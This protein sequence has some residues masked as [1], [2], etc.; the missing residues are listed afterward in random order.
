MA[1]FKMTDDPATLN[2]AAKEALSKALP[3]V[4]DIPPPA[5]NLVTLPGGLPYHDA[6]IRTAEVR[7][8][9]GEHEELLA[10]SSQA[11]NPFHFINVLL[12]SG[13]VRLGDLDSAETRK[14]LKNLLI[15]DRDQIIIGIRKATYGVTVEMP[16]WR[17]PECG[18]TSEITFELDDDI[19]VRKLDNPLTG[20]EF[21]VKLRGD[22]TA[23]VRLPTGADQFSM[24][25]DPNLTLPERNTIL[26]TRC[27]QR[28]TSP[29]GRDHTVLSA[30]DARALGMADRRTILQELADRQPGPR[31]DEV[32][33]THDLCGKEVPVGVGVGDLFRA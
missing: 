30:A 25:E 16:F 29:D 1:D 11:K 3:S 5:D 9:T 15:G 6:V 24:W 12:E 14:S 21:D 18:E 32:K 22:N 27:L 17:C 8:L 2:A 31:L 19:E 4:P 28:V 13:V 33:L 10:K 7:E 23:H 20:A 26:L